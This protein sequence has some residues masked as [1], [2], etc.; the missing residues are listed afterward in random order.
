MKIVLENQK[1]DTALFPTDWRCS[2][3]IVGL[4]RYFRQQKIDFEMDYEYED[5]LGIAYNQDDLT[6]ERYLAFA[7]VFFEDEFFHKKAEKMLESHEGDWSE[8]QIKLVNENLKANTILKKTVKEKFDGTN[9]AEIL[10]ILREQRYILIQESFKNKKNLY[11][12]FAN[13]NLFFTEENPHCR[14]LGYTVDEGRK[15]KSIAYQFDA[16]TFLSSDMWEFDWIPFAFSKAD[17]RIRESFFINNNVSIS[18][19]CHTA[20]CLREIMAKDWESKQNGRTI[21]LRSMAE[22]KHFVDFDVE[23]ISKRSDQDYFASLF[24]RKKPLEALAKISDFSL[25]QFR[26]KLGEDYWIDVQQEVIDCAINQMALDSLIE[27]LLKIKEKEGRAYLNIVIGILITLS[28]QWGEQDMNKDTK[29]KYAYSAQKAGEK[30][31]DKFLREGNAN[32]LKSYRQKLTSA[33]VFHDYDRVN[34]ILLQLSAY[35]GISYSFAYPL[36]EDGEGNKEIVFAF[37]NALDVNRSRT[38]Q[39]QEEQ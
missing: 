21:L 6:K 8:E 17:S 37:I 38:E 39:N 33:I 30:T 32:K 22:T 11:A 16:G 26:Y 18:S 3:A 15:T 34:E 9:S 19:L 35:I 29:K 1:Y 31:A 23:V 36:F 27:T 2:A 20:D 4:V 24:I 13:T 7:E 5:W 28:I 12:N 10:D 25:L 14:L